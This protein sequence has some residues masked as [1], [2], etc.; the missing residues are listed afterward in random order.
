MPTAIEEILIQLRLEDKTPAELTKIRKNFEDLSKVKD[1]PFMGWQQGIKNVIKD[2]KTLEKLLVESRKNI[3][4]NLK[5]TAG[6]Y[7]DKTAKYR[8]ALEKDKESKTAGD[9]IAD[10]SKTNTSLTSAFKNVEKGLNDFY[11]VLLT[12]TMNIG[13]LFGKSL[14]SSAKHSSD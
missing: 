13:K 5:N 12:V 1:N 11:G 9:E 3:N 8:K 7:D 10:S 6:G 4:A 2:T 14:G